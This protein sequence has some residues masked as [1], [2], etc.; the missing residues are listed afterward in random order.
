MSGRIQKKT[1]HKKITNLEK[2]QIDQANDKVEK[3]YEK[4]IIISSE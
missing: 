3:Q 2:T 4:I 1:I